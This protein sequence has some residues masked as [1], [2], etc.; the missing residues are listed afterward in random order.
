MD[1]IEY[2]G[3]VTTREA[4]TPPALF[5][6]LGFSRTGD[7]DA[8]LEIEPYPEICYRGVLR[9]S[10]IASAVDIVGSLYAREVAGS[11]STFTTD[12]S[13]R[14]PARPA[15]GRIVARGRPLRV[16]RTVIASDVVLEAEGA[17]FAYGQTSFTRVPRA[18]DAPADTESLSMPKVIQQ[19]PLDQCLPEAIGVEVIDAARGCVRLELLDGLRNPEGIMQGTVVAVLVEAAAEALAECAAGEPQI[20]TEIDLRYL[21]MG[22]VGPITAEAHWIGDPKHGMIRALMRDRGNDDRITT[23]ALLRT[24]SAPPVG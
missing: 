10:V 23:S 7:A 21:A 22:R 1:A 18:G 13:V 11:D 4:N 6:R 20:V 24:V 2:P 15:P 5:T 16:G 8:P 17:T 14:A 3:A 19:V 12:L 9:L